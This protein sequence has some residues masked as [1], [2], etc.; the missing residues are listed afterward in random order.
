MTPI[1]QCL[2][3]IKSRY[4]DHEM[5]EVFSSHLMEMQRKMIIDAWQSGFYQGRNNI[6]AHYADAFNYYER[7]LNT[8]KK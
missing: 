1:E 6:Q 7:Q 2:M 3:A 4:K 5:W 8:E